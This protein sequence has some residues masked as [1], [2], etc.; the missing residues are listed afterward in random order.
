VRKTTAAFLDAGRRS[1]VDKWPATA[2]A[3]LAFCGADRIAL[4]GLALVLPARGA[5]LCR[6]LASH[7]E[8]VGAQR[9]PLAENYLQT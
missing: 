7:G 2:F 4:W 3:V 8:N 6:S 9:A 5:A 1:D